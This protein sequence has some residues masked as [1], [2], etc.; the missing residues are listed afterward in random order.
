MPLA[1]VAAAAR[2][3]AARPWPTGSRDGERCACKPS[4]STR[5][6]ASAVVSPAGPAAAAGRGATLRMRGVREASIEPSATGAF[7]A[8]ALSQG[9]VS[10][11]AAEVTQS[12]GPSLPREQAAFRPGTRPAP[13]SFLHLPAYV[14]PSA[15]STRLHGGTP[16]SLAAKIATGG[17]LA[18]I[19]LLVLKMVI[20][21]VGM[22]AGVLAVA[23][24]IALVVFVIW[25]VMRLF[26]RPRDEL[27]W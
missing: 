9:L 3:A 23:V 14:H 19:G 24:K 17:I 22:L 10:E 6:A 15:A 27:A 4:P 8:P 11:L 18:F 2:R 20:G 16:M 13:E 21:L 1:A 12:R 5:S 7:A 26:R 25:L